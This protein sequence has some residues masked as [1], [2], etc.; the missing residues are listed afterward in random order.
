MFRS[1]LH[2]VAAVAALTPAAFAAELLVRDS[3]TGAPVRA[4]LRI[5]DSRREIDGRGELP[6]SAGREASFE[7]QG[8]HPLRTRLSGELPMAAVG[9]SCGQPAG[10]RAGTRDR[11]PTSQDRIRELT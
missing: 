7:A 11:I 8:H 2:T 1:F 6:D 4:E 10:A 3:A 9:D 5:G